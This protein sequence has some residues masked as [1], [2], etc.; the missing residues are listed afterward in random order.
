MVHGEAEEGTEGMARAKRRRA[1][2]LTAATAKRLIESGGGL[3]T[4]WLYLDDGGVQQGPFSTEEMRA[5]YAAGYLTGDRMVK[6]ETVGREI[7]FAP[8]SLAPELRPGWNPVP[9]SPQ[10]PQKCEVYGRRPFFA[11]GSARDGDVGALSNCSDAELSIAVGPDNSN[12]AHWAAKNGHEA[13][14]E[15]LCGRG[16]GGALF[17]ERDCNEL[18]AAH[19]AAE[20]GH[21][22]C[23]R[24]LCQRERIFVKRM[25]IRG[26]RTLLPE[27]EWAS[28]TKCS[29]GRKGCL[30][31]LR[32][33]GVFR[34][35]PEAIVAAMRSDNAERCLRTLHELGVNLNG[36]L[37]TGNLLVDESEGEKRLSEGQLFPA[38]IAVMRGD[39][40]CLR[41][42]HECGVDLMAPLGP[43]FYGAKNVCDLAVEIGQKQILGLLLELGYITCSGSDSGG[44]TM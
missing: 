38:L 22:G 23:L 26:P 15:L 42:L 31:V 19:Y 5:W 9:I 27:S 1:A 34:V 29:F 2:G 20:R 21:E 13:V 32:M 24:V 33:A 6:R 14:L 25:E 12:A 4:G 18:V 8:L 16:L 35:G 3:S 36:K 7:D 43:G 39:A 44:T 10:L 30:R 37:S 41:L 17:A 11:L 28:V 40:A